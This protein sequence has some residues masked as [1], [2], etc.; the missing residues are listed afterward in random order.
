MHSFTRVTL[1]VLMIL[2]ACLGTEAAIFTVGVGGTYSRVQD[3]IDAALAAGGDN[4]IKIRASSFHELILIPDTMSSGS[5]SFT[6]GWNTLFFSRNP[7][8]ASTVIHDFGNGTAATVQ[9]VGG[10][11]RFDGITFTGN[12]PLDHGGGLFAQL[13]GAAELYLDHCVITDSSTGERGGG[14][15]VALNDT[16][17]FEMFD[18]VVSNNLALNAAGTSGGGLHVS[19]TDSS[20][21]KIAW[22]TIEGNT[23][24]AAGSSSI[25]GAGVFLQMLMTSQFEISDSILTNNILV[26]GAG[27]EYGSEACLALYA[28]SPTVAL[29]RNRYIADASGAGE[30]ILYLGVTSDSTA[31]VSDSW[32]SGGTTVEAVFSEV[33]DNGRLYFNNNTVTECAS[34]SMF[35]AG[36]G[37]QFLISVT[38]NILWNNGVDQPFLQSGT[39]TSGNLI[40][41]DPLF[42]NP[43]EK[44]Y[45]L[46]KGSPAIDIATG[47]PAGGLSSIDLHNLERVIGSAVDAGAS[48]SGNL[49]GDGFELGT[50]R[51]WTTP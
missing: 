5:L 15:L 36:S 41:V 29:R 43:G 45:R 25:Q 12:N 11:V 16:S 39:I 40:G 4:D 51:M 37:T 3:A 6:G 46:R 38:N 31:A 20:T 49:F 30:Q 33:A 32:F 19:L 48:E 22:S 27:V 24:Q 44:N 14:G 34:R 7:D 26:P 13:Y 35:L 8:P 23:V 10:T 2:L 47:S 50:T 17:K 18:C 1:G 42:V 21:G 9:H 28:G